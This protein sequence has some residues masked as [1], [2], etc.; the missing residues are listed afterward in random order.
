MEQQ[1]AS[2]GLLNT[3]LDKASPII[4]NRAKYYVRDEHHRLKNA[5]YVD[6][7][8]KWA[9][10][11]FLSN[12]GDLLKFGNAMLYSYQQKN[13]IQKKQESS[14]PAPAKVPDS[15]PTPPQPKTEEAQPETSKSPETP[16]PKKEETPPE[17]NDIN[18]ETEDLKSAVKVKPVDNSSGVL[19]VVYTPGPFSAVNKSPTP[20]IRYLPGYLKSSTMA[21]LWKPQ[22]G[23]NL[24]WGGDDLVYGLGWAVRQRKKNYGFC[25]DQQ[26]YV[27]H[28]GG[29]IGASSVLLVA[30][31]PVQEGVRLP[32]G[33][34]VTILCNMQGVGLNKLA[35]DLAKTFHGFDQEKPVKVQKVYQC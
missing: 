14:P 2:L 6:N 4:Y 11:G 12:V 31:Q 26:H 20:P 5:P 3:Y 13:G 15:V 27:T 33:V 28:T 16:L 32:Q 23:A 34:V 29:A 10:G 8:Y 30:P 24:K 19:D 7:S 18:P 35:T 21:E 9:G 1:F 17:E 25:L 22:S